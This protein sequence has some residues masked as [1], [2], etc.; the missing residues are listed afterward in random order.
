MARTDVFPTPDCLPVPDFACFS[1]C[2]PL[3]SWSHPS[4]RSRHP[5]WFTG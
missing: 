5:D 4:R 1:R 3:R 2:R